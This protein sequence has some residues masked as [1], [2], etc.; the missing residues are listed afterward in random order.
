M[1]TTADKEFVYWK[2]DKNWYK[3]NREKDRYEL[4]EL[5]PERARKSFEEFKKRNSKFYKD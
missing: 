1:T 2:S 3:I 4:T 5:A